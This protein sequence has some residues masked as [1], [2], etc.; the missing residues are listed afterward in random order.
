[1]SMAWAK[2]VFLR[3]PDFPHKVFCTVSF[4]FVM[5]RAGCVC[6]TNGFFGTLFCPDSK[7][8]LQESTIIK[9]STCFMIG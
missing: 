2:S 7:I 1:M 6:G 3:L 8:Q 9:K 5:I 4:L